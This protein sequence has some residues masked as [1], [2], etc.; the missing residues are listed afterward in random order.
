MG[1]ALKRLG[2]SLNTTNSGRLEEA[3]R[4][5]LE[6]KP[7]LRGYFASFEV[8]PLVQ[9]GDI[10]LG[11]VYSGDGF[12]AIAENKDLDYAIPDEGGT[13]WTDNMAIAVGAQ[14]VDN[15]HTFINYI[16]S[17]KAGASLTN[18]TYYG[19]PNEAARP[20]I[21][22]EILDDPRIYPPP[23]VFNQLEVIEDLGAA[24]R[25]YERIFTEVK[26]A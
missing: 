18:Y 25:Q 10:L 4:L 19:S 11:H 7:L 12:L 22:E 17:A 21:K 5:L 8:R 14:H 20:M 1:A 2:Y 9:N 16:L 15:A 26:S 3:K 23:K 13:R 6:Q 24:T